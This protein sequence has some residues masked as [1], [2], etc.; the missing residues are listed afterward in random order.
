M[1]RLPSWFSFHQVAKAQKKTLQ[2][3]A[4]VPFDWTM[5]QR[6]AGTAEPSFV[7]DLIEASSGTPQEAFNIK[8]AA[9]SMYS[10][11]YMN[12]TRL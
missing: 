5:E 8:W 1:K 4:D 11:M 10:G 9:A 2:A 6:A 7:T 3:M 12:S